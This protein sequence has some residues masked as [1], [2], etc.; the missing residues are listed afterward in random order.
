MTVVPAPRRVVFLCYD[1]ML[2]LDLSGPIEV[3][4]IAR[5]LIAARHPEAPAAY[6]LELVAWSPPLVHTTSGLPLHVPAD[7]RQL[8][9][10]LDTLIV[11]GGLGTFDFGEQ[12]ELRAWLREMAATA[13]RVASVCTGSV[14]LAHAGLVDGRRVTSHWAACEQIARHFPKVAVDPEPIFTKSDKFYTSAG[15]SA[16]M[17]LALALVG[18]DFG[19][20]VAHQVARWLV[21]YLK[22]P[23]TQAQHSL[24]LHEQSAETHRLVELRAWIAEHLGADLGVERLAR[25]VGMSRRNFCRAFRR[26]AGMAPSKFVEAAR[27]EAAQRWLSQSD[28]ALEEVARRSGFASA[29]ALRRSFRRRLGLTPSDYRDSM[30]AASRLDPSAPSR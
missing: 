19:A 4:D 27:V 21:L 23:G 8:R 28:H 10:P 25:Q 5:R 20:E 6:E 1:G 13:R 3:F 24:Q 18:D 7:A 29:D 16:G 30:R 9:G 26:H 22:R 15:A 2:S 14:L 12:P 17:D 11:P